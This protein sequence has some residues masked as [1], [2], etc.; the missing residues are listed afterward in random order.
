MVRNITG[1]TVI[2]LDTIPS[3]NDFAEQLLSISK[4]P[5]GT[6][7]LAEYQSA[8]KGQ[9]QKQWISEKGKNILMSVILYPDFL[10]AEKQFFL[11]AAVTLAVFNTVKK[12]IPSAVQLNIKWPN[13]IYA[14]GK[15]I[16]GILIKNSLA[17][18]KIKYTI[19]G[20]GININQKEFPPCL[21]AVSMALIAGKEIKRK[22][23]LQELL[24]QLNVFYGFL[25]KGNF[26][27]LHQEYNAHLLWRG[28][29][30]VFTLADGSS[31]TGVI[32]GVSRTGKLLIKTG[33][34]VNS[35]MH[36]EVKFT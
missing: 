14:G 25:Q 20:A 28:E 1:N 4:Q 23:V 8:G 36:S 9:G 18:D 27:L 34:N 30:R 31:I 12:F 33:E 11:N 35:Y 21:N 19:A 22:T 17:G 6:I 24:S 3:T 16:A 7:V 15:K 2:E 32:T 29:P 5:E 13:D 10:E 26:P